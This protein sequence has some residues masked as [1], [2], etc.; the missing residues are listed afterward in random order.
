MKVLLMFADREFSMDTPLPE[1]AGELMADLDLDTLLHSMARKDTFLYNVSKSVLLSSV[2][3]RASILYRQAVLADCL[4]QP[5]IPRNLYSLTLETLETKRKNWFGVYTTTPSTIFHSSVRMLGM[6]VPYLERLRAMADEYGRDC[7]SPGFR[8]LFSMIQDELRDSRLAQIRKVLQNLSNHRDITFSARLGRGNEV[9][10]QVLRKPPRSN[11]TPWSRFFAPPAP[12]YT[13]SLDPHNDGALK[14][15]NAF[16]ERGLYSSA[17]TL[18]R[19]ADHIDAFFT[20]LRLELAFY[21]AALNGADDLRALDEPLCFP[22][23]LDPSSPESPTLNGSAL[24][25]PCLSL[26]SKKRSVGNDISGQGKNLIIIT[27]VNEGGKSTLLR[28]LALAQLMTQAGLF[29]P[30]RSFSTDIRSGLFTHFRRKEDR[31]MQSG[32]LD[33]ELVRLDRLADQ[34]DPR[35]LIF[36]NESFAATNEREGSELARQIVGALLEAGIKV[37]FVTHLY[38]FAVSCGADFGGQVLYLRAERQKEG[39]RTYTMVEGPPLSKSHGEDLYRRV[40]GE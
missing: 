4:A 29:A 1:N 37:V 31:T 33:E 24:Y 10:D 7:T 38:S 30:G 8:R 15:L 28:T 6:Y 26:R 25:N 18:A 5:H 11:R 3:D 35:S 14:S 36:F 39:Q 9:V 20:Q 2:Q 12:S 16:R 17:E 34:M 27:G 13:F 32:K 23:P 19:T 22:D 40:F 21:I